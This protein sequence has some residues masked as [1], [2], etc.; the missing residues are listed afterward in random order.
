MLTPKEYRTLKARAARF[1]AYIDAHHRSK[2]GWASYKTE[3]LPPAIRRL[4]VENADLSKLEVYEFIT[5]P[6]TTYF[7]YVNLEKREVTTWTGDTLGTILRMGHKFRCGFWP[8]ADRQA[9]R[10]QGIN[11]K[12]YAG[13]CFCG[14]GSYARVKQVKAQP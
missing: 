8:G 14:S 6:P 11:G 1:N 12:V 10:F 7:C 5:N 3:E 9:I 4:H 13:T 2:N